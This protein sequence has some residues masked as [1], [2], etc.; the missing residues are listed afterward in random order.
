[1]DKEEVKRMMQTQE[2]YICENLKL[3][4]D[5][6]GNARKLCFEF[7]SKWNSDEE[8][9]KILDQLFGTTGEIMAVSAPFHCDY[10]FNIFQK[11]FI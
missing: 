11:Q 10:G 7:N 3:P 8:S 6:K 9:K 4:Q 1:M 5:L 2:S